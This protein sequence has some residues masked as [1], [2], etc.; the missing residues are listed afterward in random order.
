MSP[1]TLCR[2]VCL[3]Y[4][5]TGL[6]AEQGEGGVYRAPVAYSFEG[7]EAPRLMFRGGAAHTGCQITVNDE[8]SDATGCQIT[9]NVNTFNVQ[10]VLAVRSA[11]LAGRVRVNCG[12]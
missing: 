12:A 5:G 2:A 3:S 4:K 9:A 8:R 7:G 10:T 1:Q 6:R 11:F